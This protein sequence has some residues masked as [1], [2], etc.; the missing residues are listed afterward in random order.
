MKKFFITLVL[1]LSVVCSN[2]NFVSVKAASLATPSGFT[3][4]KSGYSAIKVSWKKVSGAKGYQVYNASSKSGTYKKVKEFTSGS[5]VSFT[6]SGLTTGK[7]YYYK[8][9]SFAGSKKSS[10]TSVKSA[11]PNIA[12]P[13]ISEKADVK[14]TQIKFSWSSVKGAHGYQIYRKSNKADEWKKIATVGSSTLSYT[15]KTAKSKYYYTVRGYR[16]VNDKKVGGPMAEMVQLATLKSPTNIEHDDSDSTEVTEAV[17]TWD[18]VKNATGYQVYAKR[19]EESSWTYKGKTSSTSFTMKVTHGKYYDF[20]VRAIYTKNG[21]TSYGPFK[22]IDGS[23]CVYWKPYYSVFSKEESEEY[24]SVIVMAVTNYSSHTK[25]RVY[26]K[27]AWY[28]DNVSISYDRVLQL[29]E[30]ETG[31]FE[32][33]TYID[34]APGETE[35][36]VWE[37]LGDTTWY[38]PKGYVNF[39]FRVDG[40]D[41]YNRTSAYYGSNYYAQ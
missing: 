23:W 32:T 21:V 33:R 10:F 9:R 14:S 8:V 7:T 26:N 22:Q 2:L 4:V 36:L 20:K 30:A 37:V 28:E 29:R 34:I 40:Q 12:K 38:S 5:S 39:D 27:N 15:D 19:K 6:H 16:N 17:I 11:T 25:M 1:V 41:Y 3:V 24:C 31:N 35:Y 18:S 13:V